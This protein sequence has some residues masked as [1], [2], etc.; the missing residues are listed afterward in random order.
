MDQMDEGPVEVS[1]LAIREALKKLDTPEFKFTHDGFDCT[2]VERPDL[3]YCK[4]VHGFRESDSMH[5]TPKTLFDKDL[6]FEQARDAAIA[7]REGR[8]EGKIDH[9][10]DY[11]I[12]VEHSNNGPKEQIRQ[13]ENDEH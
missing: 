12:C 6:T 3:L 2:I 1:G 5:W 7:I 11:S 9:Y 13:E 8:F 4:K 10:G